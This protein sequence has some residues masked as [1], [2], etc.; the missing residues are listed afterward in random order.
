MEHPSDVRVLH[1]PAARMARRLTRMPKPLHRQRREHLHHVPSLGRAG[2]LFDAT[3]G[4]SPNPPQTAR[5]ARPPPPPPPTTPT[6]C[7][8]PAGR[9]AGARRSLS[10]QPRSCGDRA[11]RAR[12]AAISSLVRSLGQP[13]G[14][15]RERASPPDT[16]REAWRGGRAH[17]VCHRRKIAELPVVGLCG[18]AQ[19]HQQRDEVAQHHQHH[20]ACGA[21]AGSEKGT[22]RCIVLL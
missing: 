2:P 21:G 3:A 8:P 4:P 20:G 1:A 11:G 10:T 18:H 16:Q 13:G 14:R 12:R 5:S 19:P 17:V 7:R 15:G 6:T 9:R 22:L